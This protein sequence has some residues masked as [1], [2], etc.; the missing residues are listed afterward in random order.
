MRGKDEDSS[1]E[2]QGPHRHRRNHSHL[3][4]QLAPFNRSP[5][6]NRVRHDDMDDDLESMDGTTAVREE[7][8]TSRS[9]TKRQ[10]RSR[11][12]TG[13]LLAASS[14]PVYHDAD[15]DAVL[16]DAESEPVVSEE[17]PDLEPDNVPLDGDADIEDDE[18]SEPGDPD[19]PNE[20][21]YCYCN[22][23]SYGEM[24]A[25]DNESC[26]REWFHLECTGLR[27]PPDEAVK[28]YCDECKPLFMAKSKGRGRGA[29]RKR[30]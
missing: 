6:L 4:K 8:E 30:E 3:V 22:R 28:W 5:D 9:P 15:E 26:P 29:N 11:R 16:M 24:I 21:K 1:A 10:S 14:P 7:A 19:D 2:P 12:N 23:G 17:V 13:N 18:D 25:C 27:E 20:P